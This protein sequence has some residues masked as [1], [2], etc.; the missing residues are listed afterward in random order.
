MRTI[1][2]RRKR[3]RL[4]LVLVTVLLVVLIGTLAACSLQILRRLHRRLA[5]AEAA[6]AV[7]NE[8]RLLATHLAAQPVVQSAEGAADAW[9]DFRRQVSSLYTVQNGLQ[10]VSVSK[11]G[12]TVF[13]HQLTSID[14]SPDPALPLPPPE[15]V[16]DVRMTRRLLRLPGE[17]I[18][19]VV[20]ATRF[21]GE[22]GQLRLVEVAL[23]KEAVDR[24]ERATASAIA[25]MF[26]LSL[27]TIAVAFAICIAVVA[28]MMRREHRREVQ[29]REEEHLAF[30][31]VLANGI[32][33]DFRNPMSSMRLDV[34]M[35][36][37]EVARGGAARSDRIADLAARVRETIDR[38]DKVFQEFLYVSKP[39]SAERET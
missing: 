21:T 29:R 14:G 15:S 10:Y 25:S 31:G 13:Q 37:R 12:V 36:G 26:R 28:W 6:R 11:D 18:P 32:V 2:E 7:L 24:E 16:R 5:H 38:L 19:V 8:G 34:Q 33:H 20:F 27:V 4:P 30:A 39:P 22:D 35:L 3:T 1:A 17:T 23:R 9:Q